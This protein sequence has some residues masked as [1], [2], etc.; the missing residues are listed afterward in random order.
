MREKKSL[1]EWRVYENDSPQRQGI[2]QK[3][4]GT[5]R[6]L[7][8]AERQADPDCLEFSDGQKK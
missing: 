4:A 2:M 6:L 8:S 1:E 3:L 7:R 5:L